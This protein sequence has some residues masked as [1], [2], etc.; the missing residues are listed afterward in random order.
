MTWG[1]MCNSALKH[2]V[3]I[4]PTVW[5]RALPCFLDERRGRARE[6]SRSAESQTPVLVWALKENGRIQLKER[7]EW[8]LPRYWEEEEMG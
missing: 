1:S 7:T 6:H 5:S 2:R 3:S 4:F 8:W